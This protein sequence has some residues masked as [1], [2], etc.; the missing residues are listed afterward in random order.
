METL[1]VCLGSERVC[2]DG[3]GAIVAQVLNLLPLP[4]EVTVKTAARVSF[5][6]LD[7]IATADK[8]VL[9]DALDNGVEPGACTVVDVSDLP[10][11]IASSECAHSATVLQTI[12]FVRYVACGSSP[13]SVA[14]AGVQGRQFLCYG[15]SFSP[16][17]WSAI[18]RLVDL[19]LLFIGAKVEARTMVRD[20]CE[21]LA[22]PTT[23]Q[24]PC[25]QY[26]GGQSDE[27]F[28]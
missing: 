16:E 7:E 17:V 2:D 21:H 24:S 26:E 20:L 14:I 4:S 3:I 5:D 6:L 13:A 9:V 18:P 8:I 12:D 28:V 22:G 15:T 23:R 25:R 19:I 1:I 11:A 27:A 10:A